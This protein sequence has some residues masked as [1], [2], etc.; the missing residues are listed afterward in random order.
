[1]KYILL[2]IFGYLLFRFIVNFIIPVARTTRH[3]KSQMD[4]I[5]RRMREGQ[6]QQNPFGNKPEMK[7]PEEITGDYIDYEEVK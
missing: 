4:E 1:M 6:P 3:M 2:F 7:K 5:N